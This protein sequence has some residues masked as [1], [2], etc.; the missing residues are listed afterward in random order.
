MAFLANETSPRCHLALVTCLQRA[1]LADTI[2]V[3]IS[4]GTCLAV[5]LVFALAAND[6]LSVWVT[7]LAHTI[8]QEVTRCALVTL[9]GASYCAFCTV[10]HLAGAINA[11]VRYQV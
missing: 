1:C 6:A 2:L 3:A 8:L 4:T 9:F 11:L 7:I 5:I 10:L